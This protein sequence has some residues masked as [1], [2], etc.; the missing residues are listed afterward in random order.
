VVFELVS[1][2]E[3]IPGYRLVAEL[4]RGSCGQVWK[5]DRPGGGQVA[6]KFVPLNSAA[7]AVEERALECVIG[8]R[9]PHLLALFGVWRL[10]A[11]L[12]I[13][14]ELA[15]R[16]LLDCYR[17]AERAGLP[18]IPFA[19]LLEQMDG[20]ARGL[21]YLNAPRHPHPR[22]DGRRVSFQHRDIKP[23]N[24]F[25]VGDGV[26]V[27]DW[28]LIRML[29]DVVT[30]H[31]GSMTPAYAA[32]EFFHGKTSN[33]SDQY[34]LAVS[35]YFLRT[36]HLPFAGDLRD[37][38]LNRPPDLSR[39]DDRRERQVVERALA[40][41]PQERWT[42]CREFV[43]ALRESV[44]RTP[45]SFAQAGC[46]VAG[47]PT[48]RGSSL[49][50]LSMPRFHY[51]SVVPP[52]YFIDRDRELAEAQQII[53]AGQSFLIVGKHRVGKTSFCHKLIHQLMG[54]PDNQVLAAYL[55]LQQLLNLTIETFLE[56]TLLNL[57][58]EIARQVFRCKYSDLM[59]PNPADAHAGLA[60][61]A[62]FGSFVHIFNLVRRRTQS[63]QG[64]SPAPLPAQEFVQFTNDLLDLVRRCGWSNFAIFYDEANRLPRELS[65]DLLVSHA[66]ALNTAGVMSVYVAS[67]VM[68]EA[69]RPLYEAFGRE[70][71]LGSF[72]SIE[73]LRRLLAR[74]YFDDA[75]RIADLPVAGE[76]IELLWN[77][78]RG[79]PF[80]IQL[81]AGRSFDLARAEQANEVGASHVAGA[82]EAL[83]AEKRFPFLDD[84]QPA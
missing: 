69:F 19:E 6:L 61:D 29:V 62:V 71:H 38:H 40:K 48:Q 47:L 37:G 41:N 52:P 42:T 44:R 60:G 30:D 78:A 53:A 49:P 16:T 36:G 26:K 65:I 64:V 50:G 81:L 45:F 76:A 43:E 5:A 31:T 28:G 3:P 72:A 70:L 55:N 35:Y 63:V 11:F 83:K 54:S 8:I 18:G 14:M 46:S 79:Q 25:L 1:G 73:D 23:T 32:P 7:G 80:P 33:H 10:D 77:V 84:S 17:E 51:G 15:D 4:G 12:L 74:Y 39:L 56:H 20:A 59:R 66:E 34:S 22:G 9:H 27:G 57:M 24:L 2:A 13:G 21:D 82:C 68:A 58:G 75:S 67:P